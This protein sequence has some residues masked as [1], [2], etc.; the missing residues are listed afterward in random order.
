MSDDYSLDAFSAAARMRGHGL[1]Q[2]SKGGRL[3]VPNGSFLSL[4]VLLR[5][6]QVMPQLRYHVGSV[7]LLGSVISKCCSDLLIGVMVLFQGCDLLS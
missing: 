7:G 3:S 2:S 5:N 1:A 4:S 6:H